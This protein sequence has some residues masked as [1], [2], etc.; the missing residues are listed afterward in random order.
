MNVFD[1]LLPPFPSA[2]ALR[3]LCLP[4][5]IAECPAGKYSEEGAQ[6]C[7]GCDTTQLKFQDEAGQSECKDCRCCGRD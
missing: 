5:S 7:V 4:L 2:G 1:D 6:V 3:V